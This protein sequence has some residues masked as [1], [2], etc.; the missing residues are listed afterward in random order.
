MGVLNVTPDSFA[1]GGLYLDPK[2]AVEAALSL[3]ESGA[4]LI[5]V[6]GESTRPG[7]TQISP[8]DEISRVIPVIKELAPRLKVPVSI[9]TYK[10]E[11]A[12]QAV[13]AGAMVINDI[14]G[15]R[16]DPKLA[17]VAARSGAALVLMHTRGRSHTMYQEARYKNV[18]NE[19]K[20]ELVNSI[21][22]AIACGVSR[23]QVIIDPGLGF[24]KRADHTFVALSNLDPFAS[25][26]RPLLV[27]P[28]RKSFLQD[29]IGDQ[30]PSNRE[31]A[32]AA[33]VT[34][35]VLL[36]AHIVRV[37]GVKQMSQVV[38]VADRL[39]IEAMCSSDEKVLSK[40]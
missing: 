19:V 23:E 9:D 25:L 1:D 29:A 28:S 34:A 35:A 36:G 4:D 5:D 38:K 33:A 17:V 31:W 14:S 37:H 16:Y 30:I 27:G 24:A 20:H 10:S 39:R 13:D 2:C 6:G 32:T 15:L 18:I 12:R 40:R 11:V 26:D 3:E 8:N 21:E 22:H 7:A